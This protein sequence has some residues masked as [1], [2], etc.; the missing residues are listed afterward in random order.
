MCSLKWRLFDIQYLVSAFKELIFWKCC[1]CLLF[2][3]AMSA[4]FVAMS[5]VFAVLMLINSDLEAYNCEMSVPPTITLS[6]VS[7]FVLFNIKGIIKLI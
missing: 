7:V 1:S 5:V 2:K 3:T 6:A 4:V